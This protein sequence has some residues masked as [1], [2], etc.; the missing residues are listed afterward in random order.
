VQSAPD[1]ISALSALE[2]SPIDLITL[3]L[4]LGTYSGNGLLAL[5]KADARTRK[6]PV[7]VV[8]SCQVSPEVRRLAEH[9]LNKPF[10]IAPFLQAI[11][12]SLRARAAGGEAWLNGASDD[13]LQLEVSREVLD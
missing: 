12:A 7:I 3:D 13:S 2:R 10:N 9:V 8:S 5:L 11:R 6:I 4:E 1:V